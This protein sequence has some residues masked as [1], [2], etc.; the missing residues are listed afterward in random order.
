MNWRFILI[1]AVAAI[2]LLFLLFLFSS[3]PTFDELFLIAPCVALLIL[4]LLLLLAIPRTRHGS[5]KLLLATGAF[6]V[7]GIIGSRFDATLRP[8]VRW[9]FFSPR[10]KTQVLRQTDQPSGSLKHVEWDDWG[11]APVGD[12]TAYVVFD[13][14]DSLKGVTGR[15]HPGV[16]RGIPCDVLRIQRLEPRWYSV[17]L[18]VNEWWDQCRNG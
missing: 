15:L 1:G 13:P 12:W 2:L 6:I 16:V 11:G 8:T 7:T 5:A 14:A 3:D 10:F 17:T 9:A 18:E 4:L